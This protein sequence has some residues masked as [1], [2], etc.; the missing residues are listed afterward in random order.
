MQNTNNNQE[1]R[2]FIEETCE[3]CG[4]ANKIKDEYKL[5][6]CINCNSKILPGNHK[7]A[8]KVKKIYE[9]NTAHNL[10][11]SYDF[12]MPFDFENSKEINEYLDEEMICNHMV[13]CEV[14]YKDGE[15][16]LD[17][18]RY[19]VSWYCEDSCNYDF[20]EEQIA[21]IKK[22]V[23]KYIVS[24][25]LGKI[26]DRKREL[27]EKVCEYYG[28]SLEI[29]PN[30]SVLLEDFVDAEFKNITDAL[31]YFYID[32]L[33]DDWNDIDDL[34]LVEDLIEKKALNT[35]LNWMDDYSYSLISKTR[36]GKYLNL[37]VEDLELNPSDEDCITK[38]T[39][40]FWCNYF[41]EEIYNKN[42]EEEVRQ[43]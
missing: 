8:V 29:R 20:S 39:L 22:N 2:N 6:E 37:K 27:L 1:I 7:D 38:H 43:H 19:G 5:Q 32:F 21:T 10:I 4:L 18:A 24:N 26:K 13:F 40:D 41:I 25:K 11:Y 31:I 23:S 30:N 16:D 36:D 12:Q 42:V 14:N 3:N 17:T 15:F 34:K 35:V 33:K 9:V 28:C